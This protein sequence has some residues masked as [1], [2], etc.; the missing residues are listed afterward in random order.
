MKAV[1]GKHAYTALHIACA[2]G[3]MVMVEAITEHMSLLK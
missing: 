1:A 2:R 3:D